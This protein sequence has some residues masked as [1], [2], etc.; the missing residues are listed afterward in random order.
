MSLAWKS[1]HTTF[2]GQRRECSRADKMT[3]ETCFCFCRVMLIGRA[4]KMTPETWFLPCHAHWCKIKCAA[5]GEEETQKHRSA[6]TLTRPTVEA[7]RIS[8]MLVLD[9]L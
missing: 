6:V 9:S 5:A 2:Y 3:P 8:S 1:L 7:S 4:D